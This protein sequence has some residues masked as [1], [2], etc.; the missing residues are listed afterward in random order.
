MNEFPNAKIYPSSYDSFIPYLQKFRDQLPVVTQE[1]ADTWIHGIM[2]DPLKVSMMRAADRVRQQC[3]S[4]GICQ[5]NDPI[6]KN[7]TRLLLKN[8]G[9]LDSH[10]DTFHVD[11]HCHP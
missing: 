8:P 11:C 9:T 6:V 10:T 7:F 4:S 1:M 5:L 3:L 2:S